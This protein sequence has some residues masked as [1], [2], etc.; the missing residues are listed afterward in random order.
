MIFHVQYV[1]IDFL[2]SCFVLLFFRWPARP[3]IVNAFYHNGL[4]AI[5]KIKNLV[6]IIWYIHLNRLVKF[7]PSFNFIS[8]RDQW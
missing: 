5:G 7:Y 2:V 4:N 3:A 1:V 8:A 6:Q